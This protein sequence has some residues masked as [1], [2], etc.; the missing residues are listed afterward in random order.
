MPT[1][2]YIRSLRAI[3]GSKLLLLPSVAAIICNDRNEILLQQKTQGDWSLP[4]GGIEPGETPEAAL[5]R[6]VLEETGLLVARHRLVNAYGGKQYRYIYQN[7]DEVEYTVLLYKCWVD[8]LSCDPTD[9]ETISLGFFARNDMPK[10]AIPY[11][12]EV[13]FRLYR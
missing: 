2:D 3:H 8:D 10:L 7:G 12:T 1:S 11:P 9:P 4:A 5:K 13:L 6:E